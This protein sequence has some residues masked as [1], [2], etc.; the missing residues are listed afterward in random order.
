M[1]LMCLLGSKGVQEKFEE[2]SGIFLF[3][4]CTMKK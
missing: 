3:L 1:D 2:F 4:R